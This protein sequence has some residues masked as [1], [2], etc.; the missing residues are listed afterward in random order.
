MRPL[1]SHNFN[2]SLYNQ[3]SKLTIGEMAF[4]LKQTVF[5]NFFSPQG[6]VVVLF[7]RRCY[8]PGCKTGILFYLAGDSTAGFFH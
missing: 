4:I 5:T 3:N 7:S 2:K 6:H 1:F 8:P